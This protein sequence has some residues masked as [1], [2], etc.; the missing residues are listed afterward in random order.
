MVTV[1]WGGYCFRIFFSILWRVLFLIC[2]AIAH[3]VVEIIAWVFSYA[4][5]DYVS[6]IPSCPTS[7]SMTLS[8]KYIRIEKDAEEKR[9]CTERTLKRK[10]ML[11]RKRVK[12]SACERR[13]AW[14]KEKCVL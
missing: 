1:V 10:A 8:L 2:R 13:S 14:Y 6:E 7:L 9:C 4:K 12:R 11:K 5:P 3:V